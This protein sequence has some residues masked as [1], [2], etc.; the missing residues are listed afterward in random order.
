MLGVSL[1]KGVD[2]AKVRSPEPEGILRLTIQRAVNCPE[3]FLG[4]DLFVRVLVGSTTHDTKIISST[5]TPVWNDSFDYLIYNQEQW[6]VIELHESGPIGSTL[7]G[8]VSNLPANRIAKRKTATVPFI[9]REGQP[10]I[11][12]EEVCTVTLTGEWLTISD[13]ELKPG[14]DQLVTVSIA[15]VKGVPLGAFKPPYRIETSINGITT[16]KSIKRSKVCINTSS[17]YVILVILY[18]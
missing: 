7:L 11:E 13:S 6:V 3:Q 16:S 15:D 18:N 10:L 17:L 4:N 12:D 1:H 9:T 8:S 14:D 5:K 2:V